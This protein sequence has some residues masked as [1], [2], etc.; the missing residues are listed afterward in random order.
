M[1]RAD[2][3]FRCRLEQGDSMCRV[4]MN[5]DSVNPKTRIHW[6]KKLLLTLALLVLVLAVVTPWVLGNTGLRDR[7][8]ASL[9]NN[10]AVNITTRKASLGYIS[11]FSIDGLHIDADE[12]ATVI[13]FERIQADK[14]W[15]AIFWD[16]PELGRFRFVRPSIGVVVPERVDEQQTPDGKPESTETPKEIALLPILTADIENASVAV[17]RPGDEKPVV[18]LEDINVTFHL[19]RDEF[20]SVFVIDPATIFDRQELTRELCD[21]GLQL[22]APLLGKEIGADGAF[23]F[24]IDNFSLPVGGTETADKARRIEIAGAVQLHRASVGL[25]DTAIAR[26]IGLAVELLGEPLPELL[27]VATETEVK[28]HI[29]DGRVHHEGFALLLPYRDSDVRLQSSGF[30]SLDGELDVVLAMQLP[31][32]HL[33]QSK[34]AKMFTSDPIRV[35]IT[36]TMED[37][38]MQL[39]NDKDWNDLLSGLLEGDKSGEAGETDEAGAAAN[40]GEGENEGEPERVEKAAETAVEIAERVAELLKKRRE[41]AK[42]REGFDD[43]SERE[44]RLLPKMRDRIQERRERRKKDNSGQ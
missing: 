41:N 8:V 25:R 16:R 38:K 19:K 20:G 12:G 26:V 15:L 29:V 39:I 35:S 14:S 2:G 4:I 37:P 7:L 43:T 3:R 40:P 5:T 27:T 30:V 13:D 21:K 24:R 9:V 33:G 31:V 32:E 28:F 10:P 23:S 18:D 6:L 11:P 42:D 34:F 44:E 17:H 22:V 1:G 36:G